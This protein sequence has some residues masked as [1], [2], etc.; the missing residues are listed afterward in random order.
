LVAAATVANVMSLCFQEFQLFSMGNKL[1]WN[2]GIYGWLM[3]ETFV[4]CFIAADHPRFEAILQLP[5]F[6]D[7]PC[8]LN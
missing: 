7:L 3:A 2:S 6:D 5:G 4:E 8:L 1:V